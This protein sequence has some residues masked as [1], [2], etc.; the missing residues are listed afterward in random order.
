TLVLRTE[1]EGDPSFGELLG[2]VRETTLG[3]YQHQE[4]PFERLVEELAPERSLAH[5]PLFQVMFALQNAGGGEL[6]LGA[7]RAER[8]DAPGETAKF[9]LSL[10]LEEEGDLLRGGLSY[11]A[12]LWEHATAERMLGHFA[13][14]LE[15]AGADAGRPLSALPMLGDDERRRVLVEWNASGR[16]YPGGCCIHDLF[17]AQSARTPAAAAV[18]HRGRATTYAELDGRANRIAHR[19]RREGVGPEARVGVC[20][21]RTPEALAALL[22]VLRAG[23]A[24]VPI[25]PEQP[26][27]RIGSMLE[28]AGVRLVLTESA[29]AGRVA[30]LGAAVLALD[31][32]R[33]ALAAEPA[34]APESGVLPENLAYAI[35]TS[36]ST[37]R[38]K[39]VM[40]QHRG[41]VDFLHFMREI[42]PAEERSRVLGATS[43][44]FDVSVAEVWGTL[45]WGGTLVLVENALELPSVAGQDVRLAVMVPTAAAELLRMGAVP[46]SVR[47]FNLAGEALTAG[48]AR[49]L[50]DLPHVEAVRNLY[51]PTEDTTYSTWS[52][53][54][55]GAAEVRIG[56]P[57]A[58]SRAYVLDLGFEPAP[59]GVPGELYLAGAGLARGYASRPDLTAERFLPDPHGP[60]GSRMYRVMDRAR[61]RP[62][63]EL[64]YLGRTDFQVKVRGFRVEPGEIEAALE[65]HPGVRE[66]VV[67]APEHAP[68]ERRLVAYVVGEASAAELRAFLRERLPAYMVPSAFVALDALPLTGS[69]KIDRRA[70]P[71]PEAAASGEGEYVAPRTP[72]EEVLAGIFAEVLGAERVGARDGFFELGGH[73]L[74]ATRVVS[75][76][77]GA[78]GV[79]LPLRAVFEVP[80]VAGLA[81][82]T[83]ALLREVP[84]TQAPPLVPVSRDRPLPLSFAQ[85][86]LWFID[87]LQP[88]SP[89]YNMPYPL[90]LRGVLDVPALE[91]SLTE[92]VRRHESLRT[93]FGTVGEEPVQVIDP[94]GP[95]AIPIH[96]LRALPEAAREAEV[97]RLA[98]EEALR[99]FD[100]AAGPL[101]RTVLVRLGGAEWALLVTL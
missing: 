42:V 63:G 32:E 24:Y 78:L 74:L 31:A 30:G 46:E 62:D 71:A 54:P 44:S 7:L 17:A 23:G 61:W 75:R 37:G 92:I 18:V 14:L 86:R 95:V 35:F 49:A 39:G 29:L 67:V 91:R 98:T 2:R 68:G 58:N 76:V 59:V 45:C 96:D 1:L 60:A 26:A 88:G 101:L 65:R 15:A 80:T 70:L 93:R 36:G 84:G 20:M 99:P 94:A 85:Q 13:A 4:I 34:E 41:T 72:T 25:D 6:R 22:G 51:G 97:R 66:A 83:D 27:E 81:A 47:A 82:R 9:D 52:V 11:R 87:R 33:D 40:I 16:D 77:R 3:A 100:L 19:L 90:R 57:V 21:S 48:L 56:R 53:V 5:T 8:L 73:S 50:Y 89:A 55:R 12:E 28:D 43:F 69:G 10:G 79:E 38:P 64:E